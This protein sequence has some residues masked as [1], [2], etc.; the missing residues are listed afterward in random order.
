MNR[1]ARGRHDAEERHHIKFYLISYSVNHLECVYVYI[2][3]DLESG[4]VFEYVH[5]R[6][7]LSRRLLNLLAPRIPRRQMTT[8]TYLQQVDD[9]GTVVASNRKHSVILIW[10]GERASEPVDVHERT[11]CWWCRAGDGAKDVVGNPEEDSGLRDS[12]AWGR[13]TVSTMPSA[14]LGVGDIPLNPLLCLSLLVDED[15]VE[16]FGSNNSGRLLVPLDGRA[17]HRVGAIVDPIDVLK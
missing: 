7:L 14:K 3:I 4:A 1:N 10:P 8:S 5:T 2:V 16:A 17:V 13:S 9:R 11:N 12:K 6:P 15:C